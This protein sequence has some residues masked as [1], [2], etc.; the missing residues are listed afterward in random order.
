[1]ES[2]ELL[3]PPRHSHSV[4]ASCPLL[5][6]RCRESPD[7][8]CVT[9]VRRWKRA[10]DFSQALLR[11]HSISL[12]ASHPS[13][14]QVRDAPTASAIPPQQLLYQVWITG[15]STS[16]VLISFTLALALFQCSKLVV[17]MQRG[18]TVRI[19]ARHF[20]SE[21]TKCHRAY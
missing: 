2:T 17:I 4:R 13:L 11:I 15:L 7:D 1:M 18:T 6:R 10:N 5:T 9:F 12:S 3:Y 21:V 14:R 20:P 8:F 19:H 16:R